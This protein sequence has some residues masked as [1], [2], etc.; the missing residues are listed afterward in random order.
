M[1]EREA[2][3]KERL[4]ALQDATSTEALQQRQTGTVA[5]KVETAAL[6]RVAELEKAV[7]VRPASRRF[8]RCRAQWLDAPLSSFDWFKRKLAPSGMAAA[9]RRLRGVHPPSLPAC[10]SAA[11]APN[12]T[13]TR[14]RRF[15]SGGTR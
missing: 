15:W 1:I 3:L 13:R 12:P 14:T 8:V 7:K 6:A 11:C 2:R 4:K 5:D 10:L 9:A